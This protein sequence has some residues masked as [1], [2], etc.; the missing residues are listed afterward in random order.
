[1]PKDKNTR[2]AVSVRGAKTFG[3]F[4]ADYSVS[5]TRTSISTYGTGYNG[6]LLFTTV[7]QWPAFLDI[8]QFQDSNNGTFAN[9]SDFYDAYAINPYWITDNAR[10]NRQKDEPYPNQMVRY[11]L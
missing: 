1:V 4:K 8:K 2:T 11:R 3:M 7:M 5:Y 6:A 10:S 9:P